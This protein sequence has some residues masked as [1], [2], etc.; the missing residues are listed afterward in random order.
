MIIFIYIEDDLLMEI[1]NLRKLQQYD[2]ELFVFYSGDPFPD[3]HF[4]NQCRISPGETL[5]DK[6]F[7]HGIA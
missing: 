1:L 2:T 3:R 4:Y 6:R 5:H 7:F